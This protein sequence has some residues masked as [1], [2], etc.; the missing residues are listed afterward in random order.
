MRDRKR[1]LSSL[2]PLSLNLLRRK[3]LLNERVIRA[4]G[5]CLRWWGRREEKVISLSFVY[6]CRTSLRL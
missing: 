6:C 3:G 5:K 4:E 2:R 1:R